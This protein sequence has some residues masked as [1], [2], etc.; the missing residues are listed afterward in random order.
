MNK[1]E[2]MTSSAALAMAAVAGK[3]SAQAAPHAHHHMMGADPNAALIAAAADC[4]V[5]GQ[6][7]LTHCLIALADG[8][9]DMFGCSKAV[10]QT[11]AV[12]AALQGLATQQSPYLKAQA[13]IA[14]DICLE[15]EKEC[16]KHETKHKQCKDCGD[17]CA[18]CAKQCKAIAA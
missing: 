1:R 3:A 14:L 11:L 13:K 16:R 17:A 6:I 5:K 15:C 4:V 2:W 12:C 7:C 18:V 10:S 8:E 9:K